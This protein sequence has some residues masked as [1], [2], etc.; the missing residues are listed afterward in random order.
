MSKGSVRGMK[1][2][3]LFVVSALVAFSAGPDHWIGTWA[4]AAQAA[5]PANAQTFRNQT[6][7]LIVHVSAGGAKLRIRLSNVFG[8]RPLAI[9]AVHVAR[10]T[11]ASEI[12]PASDRP[13]SFDRRRSVTVSPG[14]AVISDSIDLR[15]TPLSDLAVSLFFADEAVATTSH[16]LALQTSYVSAPGDFTGETKFP[17]AKTI[18]S[19]PFLT[20]VDVAAS[21]RA[22]AIVAFGS[23]TTDGDGSTKDAN[24]RWPDVLAE[25]LQKGGRS[26]ELGVLNE[27]IIGNRLLTDSPAQASSPFGPILGEAGLKRFERDVLS[28]PSVKYVFIALGVNDILFPGFPFTPASEQVTVDAIVSGYRQLI[29]RAHKKGIRVIGTTI[30]PFEGGTFTGAG[31]NVSFYTADRE[32]ARRAVNE[33]IRRSREFDAVVDFDEAVR[34]PA[35]PIRLLPAYAAPDHLHVNDAGNVAQASAIPRALFRHH[36]EKKRKESN[37]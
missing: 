37:H 19:W 12:D 35:R 21:S 17:V 27:G 5:R 34:D 33:W 15:V 8:D 10:R 22:A 14:S 31:L 18:A 36:E 29:A 30:P 23:S 13:V 9:G 20:G 2:T 16:S 25:R 7:R 1:P 32:D 28:Q 4:T 11:N 26:V 3:L 24:R 6:L